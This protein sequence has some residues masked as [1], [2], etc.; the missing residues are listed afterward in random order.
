MSQSFNL[1]NTGVAVPQQTSD[2]ASSGASP[3]DALLDRFAHFGVE[4]G[5]ERIQRLLAALGNP[6]RQVPVI[7]VAGSNGKG[8]VCAYLSAVLTHAGYRVGRYISPHLVDWTER[9]SINEGAIAPATLHHTLQTVVAAIDPNHPSPT[10]F[11]VI[12]AAAWLYFAQQQV[13]V[14]I[15][16]VGLGG[17]LDA[18]NVCDRPLVSVITSLSMEHWQR[19]GPTLADI[20]REKAGIL[21]PG[22]PA[23][24]A[25]QPDDAQA[26]LR[27]QLAA[28]D[29]PVTWVQ[30]AIALDEDWA[31]F[32][33]SPAPAILSLQETPAPSAQLASLKYRLPL[34]GAHQRI[35]SAVAIATLRILQNRG[36]HLDDPIIAEGI[37]KTRWQGRMQWLTW[38][39]RRLLIDGAHNPAGAEMLRRYVDESD[40]TPAPISWVLGMLDNKDHGKVLR[41]L[42][43][44]GDRLH[45]VP[46][47]DHLTA[48]EQ[49]LS[50]LAQELCPQLAQ[51]A[52]HADVW[53]ALAAAYHENASGTVVLCGSLYLIGQFLRHLSL[54]VPT[55]TPTRLEV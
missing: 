44:P 12:T 49:T 53:Q 55:E 22:C 11:E 10:Q 50:Q 15:M 27:T 37:A 23:V 5:L 32:V 29:C 26:V 2:P 48:D 52:T 19:L 16:E 6:H 4:L 24:I 17:R 47:P 40:R 36:W 51:V 14:A 3:V 35:N 39:G 20:T 54:S 7:H 42:L 45:L 34:G 30:P 21:K 18:T 38:Q 41:A 13:D 8:S 25:P 33:G 43:R 9:I 31:E 28:L 1:A 46:V